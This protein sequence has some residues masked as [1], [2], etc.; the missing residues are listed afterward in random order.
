MMYQAGDKV[1]LNTAH[2][3]IVNSPFVSED[4]AGIIW[5]VTDMFK[6][7]ISNR[8][9]VN[10]KTDTGRMCGGPIAAFQRA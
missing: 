8:Y 7:D 10:A 6:S 5:T 1:R 4:A 3:S 9:Q 2:P